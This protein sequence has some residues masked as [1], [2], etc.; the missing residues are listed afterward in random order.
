M[1]H[2]L[3][4]G[5]SSVFVFVLSCTCQTSPFH[6]VSYLTLPFASGVIC[7]TLPDTQK[8]QGTELSVI[9]SAVARFF[10]ICTI[11]PFSIYTILL[12]WTARVAWLRCWH[13]VSIADPRATTVVCWCYR[14]IGSVALHL[15]FGCNTK[16]YLGIWSPLSQVQVP[17]GVNEFTLL[18]SSADGFHQLILIPPPNTTFF[19][20]LL[21]RPFNTTPN[22]LLP[23]W[24]KLIVSALLIQPWPLLCVSNGNVSVPQSCHLSSSQRFIYKMKGEK[25]ILTCFGRDGWVPLFASSAT[26]VDLD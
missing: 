26:K 3:S 23:C 22:T 6:Q 2:S 9:M 10:L 13:A 24:W 16:L 18:S 4:T 25:V 14:P 8:V 15:V 12:L 7:L 17:T 1:R 20:P 19:S 11:S 5:L 21:A